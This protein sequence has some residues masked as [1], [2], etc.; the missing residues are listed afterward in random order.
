[1][2]CGPGKKN[3][4]LSQISLKITFYFIKITQVFAIVLRNTTSHSQEISKR[5]CNIV[6][7]QN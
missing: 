2:A 5:K 3:K 7:Q 1:M 6:N 4:T